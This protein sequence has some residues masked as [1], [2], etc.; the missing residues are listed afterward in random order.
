MGNG[1]EIDINGIKTI[2]NQIF[3]SQPKFPITDKNSL[4]RAL[5]G[6][7]SLIKI[8]SKNDMASAVILAETA[9]S[10]SQVFQTSSDI[11]DSLV[12]GSFVNAITKSKIYQEIQGLNYPVKHFRDL[13]KLNAALQLFGFQWK[14][15]KEK[16]NLPINSPSEII[17]AISAADPGVIGTDTSI[18]N[19]LEV[20]DM[21]KKMT[22]QPPKVP[23]QTPEV[24]PVDT[25]PGAT[26]SHMEKPATGELPP[27]KPEMPIEPPL[28]T[29]PPPTPPGPPPEVMEKPAPIEEP[30]TAHADEVELRFGFTY[31]I[32]EDKPK[33]CFEVFSEG[34]KSNYPGLCITRTHPRQ[35][36]QKFNLGD[37]KIH[38]LTDRKS[39]EETTLSPALETISYL[40]EGF[41][42]KNDGA[43]IL[44]DGLE[45]LISVNKFNPVLA[46]VRRLVDFISE[47]NAIFLVPISPPTVGEQELKTLEREMESLSENETFGL[48]SK[49]GTSPPTDGKPPGTEDTGLVADEKIAEPEPGET[50]ETSPP[51]GEGKGC[52]PCEGTG[53][54]FWCSGTGNCES[55]QGTGKSPE[56]T[57]CENCNGS[58]ICDSCKGNKVC[59]W[60]K[61]T[62]KLIEP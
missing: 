48:P 44:L 19:G 34:M 53:H 60:C 50:A 14:Q 10:N 58:G 33:Q 56:G 25:T 15:V 39:T 23:V 55:C 20:P 17:L 40:I 2:L 3:V 12:G 11:I 29:A 4:V 16:L 54:C 36:K 7:T 57:T 46:F 13:E 52:T 8:N 1:F 18:I 32:K 5:G 62:G 59:T 26:Q 51:A 41:S 6:E 27:V 28:Q 35:V 38:W 22:P 49:E 42:K 37:V 30:K 24:P 47:H 9:F 21:T 45:Y 61:G 31:L 43:I